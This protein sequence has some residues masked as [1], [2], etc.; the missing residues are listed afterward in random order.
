MLKTTWEP[1]ATVSREEIV[2]SAETVLAMPEIPLRIKE[3]I[4]RIR[5]LEM[6]WDVGGKAYEP[7]DPS[8]IAI[9]ADAKKAGIFLLHGGGGDHRSVE[10]WHCCWPVSWG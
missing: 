2:A 6:D 10:P 3:H 9:G 5:V 4:Y 7:Q 1:P 8:Q